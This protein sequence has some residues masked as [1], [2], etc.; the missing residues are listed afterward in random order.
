MAEAQDLDDFSA[1]RTES[2]VKL[3]YEVAG[4]TRVVNVT[5]DQLEDMA[6]TLDKLLEAS[7][8]EDDASD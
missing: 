6:G 4:T 8:D 7:D 2:G 3:T 1:T 5:L